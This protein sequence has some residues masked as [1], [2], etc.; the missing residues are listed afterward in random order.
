[1]KGSEQV[2][3]LRSLTDQSYALASFLG[4]EKSRIPCMLFFEKLVLPPEFVCWDLRD[5]CA[6]DV[7]VRM[8]SMLDQLLHRCGWDRELP[9]RIATIEYRL[10][11]PDPGV[12]SADKNKAEA[13]RSDLLRYQQTVAFLSAL[14]RLREACTALSPSCDAQL[15]V[16]RLR[17]NILRLCSEPDN[18]SFSTYVRRQRNNWKKRMPPKLLETMDEFLLFAAR[19]RSF[20]RRP[21]SGETIEDQIKSA[22]TAAESVRAKLD[23]HLRMMQDAPARRRQSLLYELSTLQMKHAQAVESPLEV[24]RSIGLGGILRTREDVR[25]TV[26][27]AVSALFE[28]LS[29]FISYSSR[30]TEFAKRLHDDLVREGVRCWFAPD[31]LRVGDKFRQRIDDSIR[32]HDKLLLVLSADSIRSDWVEAEVEAAFE[33]ERK[34]G[35]LV[36]LPI[37]LDDEV[38]STQFA[39]AAN[40]RRTRHIGDFRQSLSGLEYD[41]ALSRLLRDLRIDDAPTAVAAGAPLGVASESA[42]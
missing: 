15:P 16:E 26:S 12:S 27:P 36:L 13:L 41:A 4:L 28:Y 14:R 39:W 21:P 2:R 34:E 9:N 31:D 38:M 8:R 29:C 35:R 7:V 3:F 20:W 17:G 30:D 42:H 6:P 33:R 23:E 18:D 22:E 25:V 37:K 5:I 10:S 1:M 40:I 24:L 32:A 19:R 11:Q